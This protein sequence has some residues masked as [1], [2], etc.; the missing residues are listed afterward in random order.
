MSHPAMP[1]SRDGS[2]RAR[3]RQ[4]RSRYVAAVT[5]SLLALGIT[6]TALVHRAPDG[7]RGASTA[8]TVSTRADQARLVCPPAPR[9]Q[10]TSGDKQFDPGRGVTWSRAVGAAVGDSTVRFASSAL[11]LD[12]QAQTP[13]PTPS[14]TPSTSPSPTSAAPASGDQ[15]TEV[16]RPTGQTS[17]TASGGAGT[18]ALPALD[19]ATTA[20]SLELSQRSG[21][22]PSMLVAEPENDAVPLVGGVALSVAAEGDLRGVSAA[23]CTTPSE[24][25]WLVGGRAGEGTGSRVVVSNP[26]DTSATV[27]LKLLTKDGTLTPAVGTGIVV[28]PRTTREV[29]L[30]SLTP[31]QS[32]LA[33][34]VSATG[35]PVTAFLVDQQLTGTTPG[36]VD[37]VSDSPPGKRQILLGRSGGAEASVL[38]LAVPGSREATVAFRIEDVDGTYVKPQAVTLPGGSSLDLDV[39]DGPESPSRLVVESDEPVLAALELT[40]RAGGTVDRTWMSSAALLSAPVVVPVPK[41]PGVSATLQVSGGPNASG[42]DGPVTIQRFDAAGKR[43]SDITVTVTPN[44]VVAVPQKALAGATT[45]VLRPAVPV[46]AALNLTGKGKDGQSTMFSS[47]AIPSPAGS[48]IDTVVQH[49]GPGDWP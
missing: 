18:S 11:P 49:A 42:T 23:A 20:G 7:G 13:T 12:S 37:V 26:W 15:A 3:K 33:V 46:Y 45:L 10:A 43:L 25:Q 41:A 6:G 34:G 19:P 44:G 14:G 27:N 1:R 40:R 22:T 48:R 36:G 9:L 16:P 4:R 2:R 5:T 38:R 24:N 39:S 32:V 29:L 35:A 17:P 47:V 8:R 31:K 21:L 28:A 30:R